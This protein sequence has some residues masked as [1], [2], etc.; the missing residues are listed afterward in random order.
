MCQRNPTQFSFPKAGA[1]YC[2]DETGEPEE[3]EFKIPM[4]NTYTRT[5]GRQSEDY[6]S[7]HSKKRHGEGKTTEKLNF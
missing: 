3:R 7:N 1:R 2:E 6:V 5:P 4:P